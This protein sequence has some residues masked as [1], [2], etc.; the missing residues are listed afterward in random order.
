VSRARHHSE[1]SADVQSGARSAHAAERL[2]PDWILQWLKAPAPILPGT[3]M[4]AFW[5]DYPK[6]FY[7]QMGGSAERQILAVRDH[8]LTF[9]GGPSPKRPTAQV[10]N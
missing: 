7:Q 8:L 2:Q 6:S 3:R 9:K 10:T 1:S 4:P 5:P